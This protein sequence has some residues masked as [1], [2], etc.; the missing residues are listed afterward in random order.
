MKN[1]LMFTAL[2]TVLALG[3][4]CFNMFARQDEPAADAEIAACAGLSGEA[5]E[6]CESEHSK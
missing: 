5:R 4:A 3:T 2:A 6:K 1:T